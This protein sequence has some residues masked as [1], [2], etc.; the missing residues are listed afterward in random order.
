MSLP[1]TT[2][3]KECFNGSFNEKAFNE[4]AIDTRIARLCKQQTEFLAELN[5]LQ[6]MGAEKTQE[7]TREKTQEKTQENEESTRKE[8]LD[9]LNTIKN[10]V[11]A[12]KT[13]AGTSEEKEVAAQTQKAVLETLLRLVHMIKK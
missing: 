9:V 12:K 3:P 11:N 7:K 10:L 1:N 2:V 8:I 6:T 5:N 4:E 13:S